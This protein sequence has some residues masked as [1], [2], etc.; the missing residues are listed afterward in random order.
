[1]VSL[2]LAASLLEL[3]WAMYPRE[4]TL[5]TSWRAMFEVHQ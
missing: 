5:E 2:F 3:H 4:V 1:M